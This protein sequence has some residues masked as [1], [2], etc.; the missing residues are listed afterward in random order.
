M[1][2]SFIR[3]STDRP[4]DMHNATIGARCFRGRGAGRAPS[5]RAHP[6]NC[7]HGG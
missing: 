1:P 3:C 7:S 2:S 5:T 4:M 6:E